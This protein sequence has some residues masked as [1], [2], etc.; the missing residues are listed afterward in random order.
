MPEQ[1]IVVAYQ[2]KILR[3]MREICE[4]MGVCSRTV[5]KWVM[6]GAPIAK[7]GKGKNIRYSAESAKLQSWREIYA[8]TG[9]LICSAP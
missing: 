6:Q 4:E 9:L 8:T 5:K 1:P 7:E 2:P 3:N